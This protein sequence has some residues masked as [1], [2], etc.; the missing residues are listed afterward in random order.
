MPRAS[1]SALNEVSRP[2]SAVSY[3]VSSI[4]A[5]P[6]SDGYR[7][8]NLS[9][10]SNSTV[11][12]KNHQE[13]VLKTMRS[14]EG[15]RRVERLKSKDRDVLGAIKRPAP[16]PP[17]PRSLDSQLETDSRK[18]KEDQRRSLGVEKRLMDVQEES[19]GKI[20]VEASELPEYQRGEPQLMYM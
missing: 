2:V 10:A 11:P 12:P 16:S 20:K 9:F 13:A 7:N 5:K 1:A 14:L 6:A 8:S 18:A 17:R 3:T 4:T 15:A 19:P